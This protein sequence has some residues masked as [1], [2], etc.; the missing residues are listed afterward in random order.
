M[1]KGRGRR[2]QTVGQSREKSFDIVRLSGHRHK[3]DLVN[4]EIGEFPDRAFGVDPE[5][6]LMAV[7]RTPQDGKTGLPRPEIQTVL[8][9]TCNTE[10]RVSPS[11]PPRKQK[12]P[13]VDMLQAVGRTL[14]GTCRDFAEKTGRIEGR[15]NAELEPAPL[16]VP[17]DAQAEFEKRQFGITD[18]LHDHPAF[19][20]AEDGLDD[21][22]DGT[23]DENPRRAF[24]PEPPG[25]FL[26]AAGRRA[27]GI[28]LVDDG[29]G[30]EQ[31]S[32]QTFRA[33]A[34]FE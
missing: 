11:C 21:R 28:V 14:H 10:R 20:P 17:M 7:G 30:F 8:S 27:P 5:A 6:P 4:A 2:G 1:G 15:G 9:G 18:R 26:P 24:E 34:P 29:Q 31:P 19:F 22:P 12:P 33:A 25:G 3:P 23:P 13:A 16:L 32:G